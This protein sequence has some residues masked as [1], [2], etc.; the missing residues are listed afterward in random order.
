M[1]FFLE[2]EGRDVGFTFFKREGIKLNICKREG[3]T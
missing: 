1:F 2:G 3:K